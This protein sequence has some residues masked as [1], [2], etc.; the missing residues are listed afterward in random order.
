MFSLLS[1]WDPHS[2]KSARS[3]NV[4]RLLTCY[5]PPW[6]SVLTLLP[7]TPRETT[8]FLQQ[9]SQLLERLR[10]C[11]WVSFINALYRSPVFPVFKQPAKL[12]VWVREFFWDLWR[13]TTPRKWCHLSVWILLVRANVTA[14]WDANS[15]IQVRAK[16]EEPICWDNKSIWVS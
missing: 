13:S 8:D 10:F 3:N 7:T 9:L 1:C 5:P 2:N 15:K 6:L 14:S 4:W 12:S 16:I 11:F